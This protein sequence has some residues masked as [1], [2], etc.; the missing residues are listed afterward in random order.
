LNFCLQ[1]FPKVAKL[2]REIICFE[3]QKNESLGEAW[4]HFDVV[5]NSGPSLAFPESMLLQHFFIGLNRKIENILIWPQE[6]RSC[7]SLL[8]VQKLFL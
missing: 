1:F 6:E 5:V 4:E 2:R 7:I 8:S 3:Q